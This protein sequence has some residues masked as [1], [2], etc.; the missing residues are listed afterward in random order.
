[1]Q[2]RFLIIGA[3]KAGT[4]TLYEDLAAVSGLYLPPEKEPNDLAYAQADTPEGVARYMAKFAAAPANAISGEAS[5]A[6][7]KRPTYEGVADRA[8]RLLGPSL[9]IIYMQRDPIK[10]MISQYHHLQGLGQETRSLNEAVTQDETYVAYSRYDWQLAPWR[11]VLPETQILIVRFED[12]ITNRPAIFAQICA[13]LGV[14]PD[15]RPDETHRNASAGKAVVKPGS[16]MAK[17]ANSH[18]YLYRIKPLIPTRMRDKIKALILPKTAALTQTL[19]DETR[20][21]LMAR[22]A[23]KKADQ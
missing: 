17:I 11:A 8:V 10:R 15:Q 12:Y 1:M 23:E 7:A 14:T 6:Y 20:A 5:T 21:D 16:L 22:L 18:V 19:S 2:P 9:K 13:F 3:M 4:T